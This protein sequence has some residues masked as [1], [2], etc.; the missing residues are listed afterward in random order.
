[1]KV[2]LATDGSE[3]SMKAAAQAKWLAGL[4]PSIEVL[5]LYVLPRPITIGQAMRA[6]IGLRYGD[7]EEQ[8]ARIG[9]EVL[10]RTVEALGLPPERVARR[11]SIGVPAEEICK[12]AAEEEVDMVIMGSRGESPVEGLL[13]GSTSHKVLQLAPCPVLLV[14]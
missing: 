10:D 4:D 3:H 6:G 11:L 1:M 13:L 8:F 2:L 5:V 7:Y 14:R 9:E 12:M